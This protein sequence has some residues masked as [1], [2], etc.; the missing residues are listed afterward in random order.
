[1]VQAYVAAKS[2]EFVGVQCCHALKVLDLRN[3]KELPPHYI[4]KRWR[5]D[6]K[7]HF[8]THNH[9]FV[10]DGNHKSSLA[11]RCRSLCRILYQIAVK[12]VEN[13]E[14]YAFKESQSDQL[15]EQIESILYT[16]LL[17]KTASTTA[18]KG[19]LQN[20][21]QN[22]SN[23]GGSHGLSGKRKKN[24]DPHPSLLNV[25]GSNKQQKGSRGLYG[26]SF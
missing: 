11:G 8:I 4:L 6:A 18:S 20:L 15:L 25:L 22:G 3:I 16:K 26:T 10:L 13:A 9:N 19:Q 21:V 14:T 5:K 2:F 17:E 12:A 7:A 1:M 24:V 23:S